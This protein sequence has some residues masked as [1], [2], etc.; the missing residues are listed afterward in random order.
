MKQVRIKYGGLAGRLLVLL[1]TVG[2][3]NTVAL[4]TALRADLDTVDK[5]L[6][7]LEVRGLVRKHTRA[8]RS[9]DGFVTRKRYG[10][11]ATREGASIGAAMRQQ[12]ADAAWHEHNNQPD[13]LARRLYPAFSKGV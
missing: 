8:P 11:L 10:W 5:T 13:Y 4:A 12:R 1:A 6:T 3:A 2:A 9:F 7:R